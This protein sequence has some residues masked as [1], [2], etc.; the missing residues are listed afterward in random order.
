MTNGVFLG[1]IYDIFFKN[2]RLPRF[3]FTFKKTQEGW[4]KGME[5]GEFLKNLKRSDSVIKITIF[6]EQ[7]FFS[8]GKQT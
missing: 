2:A 6:V 5:N 8:T 4:T 7:T 3:H 1:L